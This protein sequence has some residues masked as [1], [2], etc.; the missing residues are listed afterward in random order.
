[1]L[2]RE[3][4][5]STVSDSDKPELTFGVIADPQYADR[6]EVGRFGTEPD[7]NLPS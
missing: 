3:L 5:P 1:M 2:F 6:I 7:R 4:H